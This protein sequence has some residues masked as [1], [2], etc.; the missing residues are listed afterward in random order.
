MNKMKEIEEIE[1]EL[2]KLDIKVTKER[3]KEELE[4]LEIKRL[5]TET[6]TRI[7]ILK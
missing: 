6:D 1:I 3:V 4:E 5:E 2:G 7:E